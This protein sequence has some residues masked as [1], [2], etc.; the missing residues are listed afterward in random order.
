MEVIS[1][2][3]EFISD[4]MQLKAMFMVNVKNDDNEIVYY[5]KIV[6][7]LD[8]HQ[9]DIPVYETLNGCVEILNNYELEI[10]G[11]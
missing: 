9:T 3:Y 8:S 11:V 7:I 2:S 10:I 6:T 1:S 4:E 5:N